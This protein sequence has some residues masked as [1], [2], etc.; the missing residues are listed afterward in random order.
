MYDLVQPIIP[1]SFGVHFPKN[2]APTLSIPSRIFFES[3]A[4]ISKCSGA[5]LLL[6]SMHDSKFSQI[7]I[8]PQFFID[9]EQISFLDDHLFF[10]EVPLKLLLPGSLM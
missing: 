9:C 1:H 3:K 7:T 2:I 4:K 6:S 10:C 5:K 8:N